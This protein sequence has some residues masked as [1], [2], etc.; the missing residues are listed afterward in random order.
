[1]FSKKLIKRLHAIAALLLAVPFILSCFTKEQVTVS[2]AASPAQSSPPECDCCVIKEAP[3]RLSHQLKIAPERTDVQRIT[4]SGVVYESDGKTPA[5]DVVMYVYQTDETGRYSKRGDENRNSFAWWHGKQ[6]GWLKTNEKGE[7]EIDTIKPAPYPNGNEPAHVHAIVKAPTQK[8][9][10]Y[11]ADFVFKNDPLLNSKY[12]VGTERFWRS[13]GLAQNPNYG[14]VKLN[15]DRSGRLLGK[16]DIT[17][18]QEYDLP[19]AKSGP[20][21][22]D[23]SPAFAPQHAWGPDK[24]SH[25]CPMCKY[26]YQPGVLYWVNTN[27]DWQEVESWA[28]WLEDLSVQ[29]GE[30]NF[31]AYLI[32][33]NPQGLSREQ[34]EAK[35][36]ELGQKL[37]LQKIAL[38]YVPGLDDKASDVY[39]NRINPQTRNT[40]IVYNNRR[41]ADKFVDLS[42]TEQNTKLLESAVKR[43]GKEKELY[44][45][46]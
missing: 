30:K 26:G 41:V 19:K 2:N 32:Y 21:V 34:I 22:L 18:F 38:T 35:L 11:I 44:T 15:R 43:A 23:E 13:T 6:R 28:K 29:T 33:T 39:L 20:D 27:T 7:Y 46:R 4:L 37:N 25:A 14:G 31:K 5:R 17:L 9:C 42:F 24:G 3:S 36:A 16:R 10:Y 45:A 12:W 8:H 1:M 40:V